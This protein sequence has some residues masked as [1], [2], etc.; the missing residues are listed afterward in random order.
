M[1]QPAR[2]PAGKLLLAGLAVLFA[3]LGIALMVFR[4]ALGLELAEAALI[5]TA[6]LLTAAADVL[7]L[8]RWDRL[9][10]SRAKA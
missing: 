10:V 3:L 6:L 1:P 2:R 9:A 8:A 4:T 5:A 7:I